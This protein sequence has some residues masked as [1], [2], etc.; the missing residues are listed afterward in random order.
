MMDAM[1]IGALPEKAFGHDPYCTD[2]LDA[3]ESQRV[4]HY[5]RHSFDDIVNELVTYSAPPAPARAIMPVIRPLVRRWILTMSP[6]MKA[7]SQAAH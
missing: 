4:L 1:G 7:R 2:W 6:Y 3:E 5:Q